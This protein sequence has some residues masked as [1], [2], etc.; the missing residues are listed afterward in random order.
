MRKF[1][2]LLS[3][4]ATPAY[5]DISDLDKILEKNHQD[6]VKEVNDMNIRQEKIDKELSAE[7][8]AFNKKVDYEISEYEKKYGPLNVHYFHIHKY[9]MSYYRYRADTHYVI[10]KY[11]HF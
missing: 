3:L 7:V 6:F 5:A 4:I 2:I 11:T 10:M 9:P 8:T 1:L